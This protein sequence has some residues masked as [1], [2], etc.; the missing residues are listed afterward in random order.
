MMQV[1]LKALGVIM[2]LTIIDAIVVCILYNRKD[3]ED[4]RSDHL[5]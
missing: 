5:F 2:G 1:I 4:E 3:D